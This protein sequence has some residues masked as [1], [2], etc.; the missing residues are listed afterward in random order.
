MKMPRSFLSPQSMM[1]GEITKRNSSLIWEEAEEEQVGE[2]DLSD[3]L[4]STD[5]EQNAPYDAGDP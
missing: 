1:Y 4:E 5:K 3:I 2:D